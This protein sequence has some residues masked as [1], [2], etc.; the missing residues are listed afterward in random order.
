MS[1]ILFRYL[2]KLAVTGTWQNS[3]S[4][5]WSAL[6]VLPAIVAHIEMGVDL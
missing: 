5:K 1:F 3:V 6:K 4:R 2:H